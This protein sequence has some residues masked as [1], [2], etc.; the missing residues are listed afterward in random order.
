MPTNANNSGRHTAWPTNSPA[1]AKPPPPTAT[2]PPSGPTKPTPPPTP[3]PA[4]GSSNKPPTPALDHAPA[5][6]QPYPETAPPDIRELAAADPTR[7]DDTV[8]VPTGEESA[9]SLAHARR[10]IAEVQQRQAAEARYAAERE[11]SHQ[12]ARWHQDDQTIQQHA[13]DYTPDLVTEAAHD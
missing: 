4:P 11:H 13:Q 6:G 2:T 5:A 1:P 10:A 9:D 12:L 3:K 7:H 8:R